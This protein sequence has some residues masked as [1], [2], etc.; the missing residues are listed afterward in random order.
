[1]TQRIENTPTV[2]DKVSCEEMPLDRERESIVI[3]TAV[4]LKKEG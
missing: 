2:K 3:I 1:M 4:S